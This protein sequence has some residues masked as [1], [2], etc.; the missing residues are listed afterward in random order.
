MDLEERSR[1][2]A[3]LLTE[4]LWKR[5]GMDFLLGN[6]F[7]QQFRENKKC[8]ESWTPS[9]FTPP[10]IYSKI[11]EELATQLAQAS[12]VASSRSNRLLEEETRRPKWAWLLFV[13]PFLLN[14][15][16]FTFFGNSFSVTL[17]N[18]TNFVT[19]LIFLP[20]GYESLWIIYLLFFSFRRSYGN[21][22]IAQKYLFSI[23]VTLRNF[24]DCASLLLFDFWHISGLH[25]LCNQGR[26]VSRSIQSKIVYHQIIIPGWN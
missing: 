16:P 21:L 2:F 24:T 25:S 12:K 1:I 17:R 18:F 20:Q 13:P 10:P 26:Q 3:E 4:T 6:N 5:L 22:R 8:Q 19:I 23:S 15:S 9:L 14:A 11:G 7:P